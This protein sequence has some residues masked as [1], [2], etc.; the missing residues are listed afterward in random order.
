MKPIIPLL[1]IVL[2]LSGCQGTDPV[3]L[4]SLTPQ[5]RDAVTALAWLHDADASRDAR[6]AIQRGD[7]RLYAL[8]TRNPSLPGVPAAATSKV[9]AVCGIRYL[10]G[11]TDMVFGDTH[12]KLLQ[13]AQAYAAEY[14]KLMLDACLKQNP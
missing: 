3:D 8:A 12:L 5:E 7:K 6:Q 14:N 13:E 1:T 4:A 10:D 2:G 9:K 11:S